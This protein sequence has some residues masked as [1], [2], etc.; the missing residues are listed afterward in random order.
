MA[1][2]FTDSSGKFRPTGNNGTSSR[3][4]SMESEGMKMPRERI[5]HMKVVMAS[6]R[7][8]P[9]LF[10]SEKPDTI[11]GLEERIE[12]LSLELRQLTLMPMPSEA[13]VEGVTNDMIVED[14]QDEIQLLNGLLEGKKQQ[15]EFSKPIT[16]ETVELMKKIE[17]LEVE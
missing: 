11:E 9:D 15:K 12:K 4:K 2:G 7:N 14:Y 5:L 3:D 16:P 8:V 6:E 17:T 1:K 10:P 13:F